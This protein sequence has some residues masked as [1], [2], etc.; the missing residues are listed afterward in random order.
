MLYEIFGLDMYFFFESNTITYSKK[1]KIQQNKFQTNPPNVLQLLQFVYFNVNAKWGEKLGNAVILKTQF[2]PCSTHSATQ[3]F[4][5]LLAMM[6]AKFW[7]NGN[8]NDNDEI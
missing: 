7:E 1:W 5:Y 6:P 8:D 4:R 3:L 2:I